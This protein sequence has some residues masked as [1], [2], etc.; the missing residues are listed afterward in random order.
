MN[1]PDETNSDVVEEAH[2]RYLAANRTQHIVIGIIVVAA[3]AMFTANA[4]LGG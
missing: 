2:A 4:L 3:A 1:E